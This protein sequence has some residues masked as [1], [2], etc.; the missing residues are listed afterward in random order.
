MKHTV[1][2]KWGHEFRDDYRALGNLKSNFPNTS[3]CAFTATS[4]NHVTD[5]IQ[6]ELRL[7]DPLVLKGKVF[8]KNIYISAERR[9]TNGQAQL[10][11]FLKRQ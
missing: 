9:I 8:R 2:L 6:R 1:S 5:D 11:N 4:T 3:I 10:K 7:D